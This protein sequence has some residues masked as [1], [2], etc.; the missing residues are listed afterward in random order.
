MKMNEVT[1]NEIKA[2]RDRTGASLYQCRRAIEYANTHKDCTAI[3]YLKACAIAVY[4][5][6]ITFEDRVRS[7]SNNE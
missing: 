3:G 7:F 6:N 4:T 2:L 1:F 5:P